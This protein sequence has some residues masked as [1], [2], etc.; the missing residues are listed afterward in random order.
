VERRPNSEGTAIVNQ[1]VEGS[2]AEVAGMQR[3]DILCFAGSNGQ[4]E[5]MYDM[6]LELAKSPQRPLRKLLFVAYEMKEG[7]RLTGSLVFPSLAQNWK[8]DEFRR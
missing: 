5:M 2:Q 4:E 6:F 7:M 3:G 8:S 1:V